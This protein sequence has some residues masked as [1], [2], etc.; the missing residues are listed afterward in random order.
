MSLTVTETDSGSFNHGALYSRFG[1]HTSYEP[2]GM[3]A[4]GG[5]CYTAILVKCC[6]LLACMGTLHNR[7][8]MVLFL[9]CS[10]PIAVLL[11]MRIVSVLYS[12]IVVAHQTCAGLSSLVCV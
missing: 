4:F 10:K 5:L 6:D 11:F 12:S 9:M 3:A 7:G 2:G 8:I 1:R